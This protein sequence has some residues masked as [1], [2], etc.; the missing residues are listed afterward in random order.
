M[1]HL[2]VSSAGLLA[3]VSGASFQ[4]VCH[5]GITHAMQAAQGLSSSYVCWTCLP[6]EPAENYCIC[7]WLG[8]KL[9]CQQ[10]RPC[11][12]VNWIQTWSMCLLRCRTASLESAPTD[13]RTIMD[14][15]VIKRKL[16][17]FLF[18]SSYP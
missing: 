10:Q 5:M 13:L 15:H 7:A 17:S 2:R 1:S 18:L 9:L 6:T 4:Q 8:L 3:R 12:A 11:Q 14:T 16:K